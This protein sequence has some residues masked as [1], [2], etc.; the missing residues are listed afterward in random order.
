MVTQSRMKTSNPDSARRA[1]RA[2]IAKKLPDN[3][4]QRQFTPIALQTDL[5]GGYPA[6]DRARAS[7]GGVLLD[8]VS[9]IATRLDASRNELL[10]LRATGALLATHRSS[11]EPGGA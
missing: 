4:A 1:G 5:S 7:L 3:S 8:R 6:C 9:V 2:P 11:S 10:G